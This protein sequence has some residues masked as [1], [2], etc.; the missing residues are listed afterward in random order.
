MFIKGPKIYPSWTP[1]PGS[2]FPDQTTREKGNTFII[3]VSS[4]NKNNI[5]VNFMH[6]SKQRL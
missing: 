2:L 5:L 4:V 1:D 6:H 3:Y